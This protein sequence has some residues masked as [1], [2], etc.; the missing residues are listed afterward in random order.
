[1]AP[2]QKVP[3]RGDEGWIIYFSGAEPC[4]LFEL[5]IKAS[6]LT[7]LWNLASKL[8]ST[9]DIPL[10][11]VQCIPSHLCILLFKEEKLHGPA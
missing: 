7:D 6:I 3:E 8:F 4:T 9:E 5:T 10:G 2:N 11:T 1:M